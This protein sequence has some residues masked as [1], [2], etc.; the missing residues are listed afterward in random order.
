VI[1]RPAPDEY[2][3]FYETYISKVPQGNVIDVLRAQLHETARLLETLTEAQAGH[4]YAPGKWTT[5]EVLG[6]VTDAERIFSYRMLCIARGETTPLP[7]FDEDSYARVS[8]VNTRPMKDVVL[9]Y[10]HVRSATISLVEGLDEAAVART[11]NANG[12]PISVR[13]IAFIIAGHE[14]HHVGVLRDR[15]LK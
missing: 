9:E 4:R 12:K 15:Y 8:N 7:G 13:A 5:R 2:P 14:R 10:A 3:P 11:G 1:A 6:H